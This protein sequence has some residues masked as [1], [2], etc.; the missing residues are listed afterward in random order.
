MTNKQAALKIIEQLHRHRYQALLAGGCVRDM[1]IGREPVDYDIAT[2]AT[3]REVIRMFPRTLKIGA[4]FG[5][6]IVQLEDANIEVATFRNETGYEDGR[7]P[8]KIEFTDS[9]E[10]AARRDFTINAMFYDTLKSEVIDYF[11]GQT[12]L[13]AKVIRT[14]G[15]P[16]ERFSEDYLRMLRA[17]RFST[18]LGFKIEPQSWQAIKDNAK[19]I[20]QI[21]GERIAMELEDI[22][23]DPNRSAGAVM[24]VKSGLTEAIFPDYSRPQA[25]FALKVLAELRKNIDFTL[26]LAAFF[27]D[28]SVKFTLEKCV[29]LMLSKNQN[30]RIRTLLSNRGKLL[31]EQM[32]LAE[33]KKTASE[34][35]FDDLYE[36]QRAIQKAKSQAANN[37]APLIALKKRINHLG[38]TELKPKPLLNGHDLIELGVTQG[39]ALGK[40]VE[41]LYDAQL[42]GQLKTIDQAK[43]WIQEKLEK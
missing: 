23:I 5:V 10:D 26:A 16:A 4:H 12:D 8:T 17:V 33:L 7:H 19:S 28:C 40:L 29:V 38:N 14:V 25:K 1:L 18:Q 39:P 22:L 27:A 35:Y 34:P 37:I 3:P 30:N 2:N 42:E 20:A 43:K 15:P 9:R 13:K 36:L 11:N 32:S 6:I 21:S 31:N 41:Q 24:L